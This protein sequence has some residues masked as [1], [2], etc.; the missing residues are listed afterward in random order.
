VF[1]IPWLVISRFSIVQGFVRRSGFFYTF[2]R[3]DFFAEIFQT[4]RHILDFRSD[5]PFE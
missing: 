2:S 3:S 5:R 1:D 4:A